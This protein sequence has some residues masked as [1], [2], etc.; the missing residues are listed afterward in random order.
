ML[1]MSFAGQ[2]TGSGKDTPV[3]RRKDL[4]LNR[5]GRVRDGASCR[6]PYPTGSW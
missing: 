1:L 6:L 2:T 3:D 5:A 4:P